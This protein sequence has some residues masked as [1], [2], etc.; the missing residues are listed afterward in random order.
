MKK[1]FDLKYDK[2][3][4]ELIKRFNLVNEEKHNLK[5]VLDTAYKEIESL[6]N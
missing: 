1:E 3:Q 5:M 6:K 2:Q 4:A